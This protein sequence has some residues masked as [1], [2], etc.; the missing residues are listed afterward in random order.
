FGKKHRGLAC[1]VA[2]SSDNNR[3]IATKLAFHCRGRVV[4]AH[5]L[6]LLAT[7]RIEPTVI[8]ACCNQNSFSSQNCRA[9]FNLETGTIFIV[10]VVTERENQ[11]RCS[12]FRAKS[13]GLKLSK[14]G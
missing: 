4:N 12:K 7:F 10:F 1:G 3:F 6:K 2:A 9:T 13:V 8:R 14:P 11:R 5:V